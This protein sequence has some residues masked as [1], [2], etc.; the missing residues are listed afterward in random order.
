MKK[1]TTED[2]AR[3]KMADIGQGGEVTYCERDGGERVMEL[4]REGR[5]T[6]ASRRTL[7][8]NSQLV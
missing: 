5:I 1:R 2:K 8:I 4:A 3:T 6:R 7:S